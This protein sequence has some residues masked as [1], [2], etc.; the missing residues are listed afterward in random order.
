MKK[1]NIPLRYVPLN[2]KEND[3]EKQI[4]MLKK[5]RKLY[6]QNK[7]FTRSK[8]KSYK[9]KTSNHIINARK[10]YNVETIT[11]NKELSKATGCSI[12]SLEKI[13]KKGE[14]A[15]YSSGSRPN[16]TPQSW[17]IARLASSITSGKSAAVDF[18]ILEKGCDHK[19]KAYI[20]AK[21]S[22]KKYNYG[23]SKTRKII[24]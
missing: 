2:L 17:G 10:M 21:K 22:R 18:D 13:V 24:V 19:K 4:Q 15:Y 3:K 6:K 7:Y 5:S 16:Q 12:E 11:P 9:N 14:G 23:H 1:I 20:L 8:L